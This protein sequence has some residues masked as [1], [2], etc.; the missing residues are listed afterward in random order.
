MISGP[1]QKSL[2]S[3]G[4]SLHVVSVGLEIAGRLFLT[5]TRT[6]V[7]KAMVSSCGVC[8]TQM[9][10][11]V[12]SSGWS[13][14]S[15]NSGR[16]SR[17]MSSPSYAGWNRT[18]SVTS[19]WGLRKPSVGSTEN[20]GP[21]ASAFHRH[22]LPMSPMFSS[23]SF[24]IA[25]EFATTAPKKSMSVSSLSSTPTADPPSTM[26]VRCSPPMSILISSENGSILDCGVYMS[27]RSMVS[28]GLSESVAGRRC[29]SRVSR[30]W[31]ADS[32]FTKASTGEEFLILIRRSTI[33]PTLT[34]PRA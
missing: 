27:S 15:T 24:R 16:L 33:D 9:P 34:A 3:T 14:P 11:S 26:S 32:R 19:S 25:R 22:L 12:N 30:R 29:R 21:N 2:S 6:A 20:S 18:S 13:A 31:I 23:C 1:D 8:A 5:G 28:R 4:I 10:V 7:S 17:R